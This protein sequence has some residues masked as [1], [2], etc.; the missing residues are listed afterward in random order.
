[1]KKTGIVLTLL[2]CSV[3]L[4]SFTACESKTNNVIKL[5]GKA[6]TEAFLM[7]ELY[8]LALEDEGYTVERIFGVPTLHEAIVAGEIDVY[9][10]Y[11]GT[12]LMTV[13][14]E[15]AM[16]DPETVYT[17]VK[18][19]YKEK[20]DL[21]WLTPS[22]L[23]DSSCIVMSKSTAD[24]LGIKN[25]SDMN[26]NASELKLADFQGWSER[27]DNLIAMNRL[28]GDFNFKELVQID[29]GLKYAALESD[30]VQVIPGLTTE[31]QLLDPKFV[32]VEEDIKVWPPYYMAPI[33]RQDVLDD[34]PGI[35][36]VLNKVSAAVDNE[37]I[38]SLISKVDIDGEEYE[39]VAKEF[40][41]ANIQG[42]Q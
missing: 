37:I 38:I 19:Q 14:Q 18:E 41:A 30:E 28:Y 5:G 25:L 8:S 16:T 29:A 35:D 34:N 32:I 24:R 26:K 10:E 17:R 39:D 21:V 27:E 40:Y 7:S 22:E 12:G 9:P 4:G 2:L 11:T 31:P 23:N 36:G 42:Q 15:E 6:F 1:M 33:I 20:F 3:L 13:L